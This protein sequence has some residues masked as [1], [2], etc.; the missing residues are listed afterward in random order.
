[1]RSG[2]WKQTN[3]VMEYIEE[4]DRFAENAAANVLQIFN[5]DN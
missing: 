2:R 3:T 5:A 4:S 1:M